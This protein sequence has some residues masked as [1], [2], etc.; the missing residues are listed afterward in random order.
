[1]NRVDAVL[2][3]SL[4]PF[5]IRGY[6][7]GFLREGFG[8]LGVIGGALVAAAWWERVATMMV[9]RRWLDAAPASAVSVALLFFSTYVLAQLLGATLDRLSRS[10]ALG[11]V[12]RMAGLAFGVT[13]GGAFLGLALLAVLRFGPPPLT[14]RLR[15][16]ALGAPPV[17]LATV[18]IDASRQIIP[19]APPERQH[20]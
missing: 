16:S 20:I 17:K 14:E 7:R 3:I 1:V 10:L 11:G 12:N 2:L 19:P 15:T 5:A 6:S 13:K 9:V 18:V 4:L 8:I